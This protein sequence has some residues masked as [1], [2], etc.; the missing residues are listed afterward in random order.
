MLAQELH[1]GRAAERLR[2]QQPPLS[3]AIARLERGLGVQL[4]VRDGRGVRLTA[5]GRAFAEDAQHLLDGSVA[6]EE[7]VRRVGAGEEGIVRIGA[8]S[9]VLLEFV[10]TLLEAARARLPAVTAHLVQ[11]TSPRLLDMLRARAVDMVLILGIT[12][13]AED[14]AV[15]RLRSESIVAALPSGHRLAAQR[16]VTFAELADGPVILGPTM[17]ASGVLQV[18]RQQLHRSDSPLIQAGTADTLWGLLAQ[19]AAGVGV[20][21]VPA[22]AIRYQHPGLV[23]RRVSDPGAMQGIPLHAFHHADADPVV[24]RMIEL[25]RGIEPAVEL[26]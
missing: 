12:A 14:F 25:A 17:A 18:L 8:L 15:A 23:Y 13:G 21:V 20:A 9:T 2:I 26:P 19:A 3:Q 5:A 16:S 24:L 6:A 1:F 22:A 7:R 11:D 4:L 10:P